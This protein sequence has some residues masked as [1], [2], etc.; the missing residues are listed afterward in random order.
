MELEVFEIEDKTPVLRY[1]MIVENGILISIWNK[2]L[3]GQV[4]MLFE[5]IIVE[6]YLYLHSI[7]PL[8]L[9][10]IDGTVNYKFEINTLGWKN[11]YLNLSTKDQFKLGLIEKTK[12]FRKGLKKTHKI[13][14]WILLGIITLLKLT[15]LLYK[16]FDNLKD[17]Q[18]DTFQQQIKSDN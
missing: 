16:N 6:E 11:L 7:D 1:K 18:K 10:N 9:L 15:D 17:L 2:G 8:E 14:L 12:F 3:I 13:I 5:N 4:G